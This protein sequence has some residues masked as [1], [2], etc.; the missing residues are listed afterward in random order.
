MADAMDVHG[1]VFKNGAAVLLA[2]VVGD[3]GSAVVQ[4]DISS[5]AYSVYLLSDAQADQRTAVSGH[6]DVALVIAD[7]IFDAMQTDSIWTV[8]ATGYNFRLAL[9]VSANQAFAVA[10]RRY[11]VEVRLTPASGQVIV[12]RFRCNAI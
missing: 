5:G 6:Q 3:D 8:D 7:V 12:V 4:A 1:N 10:G 11:L 2:R 9:D